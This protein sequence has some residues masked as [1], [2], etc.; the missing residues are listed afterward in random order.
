MSIDRQAEYRAR[1]EANRGAGDQE[2]GVVRVVGLRS[3]LLV[4]I[5]R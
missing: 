3:I 5:M 2:M 4:A 1:A